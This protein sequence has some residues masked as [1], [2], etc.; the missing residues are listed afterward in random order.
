MSTNMSI[1]D[2]VRFMDER[3]RVIDAGKAL[4]EMPL[5]GN[6]R[7]VL[8]MFPSQP[9]EGVDVAAALGLSRLTAVS[10]DLTPPGALQ[11]VTPGSFTRARSD[12]DGL[13]IYTGQDSELVGEAGNFDLVARDELTAHSYVRVFNNGTVE[14]V[15]ATYYK[16]DQPPLLCRRY[17]KDILT[18]IPRY[19]IV[20]QRL[21]VEL[22][23]YVR[24]TVTGVMGGY[25]GDDKS[26]VVSGEITTPQLRLPDVAVNTFTPGER[27]QL[28]E[29]MREP[30]YK[31]WQAAGLPRS[32]NYDEDDRWAGH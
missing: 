16:K 25:I 12:D 21:G 24:L 23:V 32:M 4:D 5:H 19:L 28:A 11:P 2:R 3:V 6:P 17:E 1:V 31:V 29:I 9:L 7:V 26:K 22:P 14:A 15:Q 27:A 30:F 20:Q 18:A 10:S 8:H 13:L